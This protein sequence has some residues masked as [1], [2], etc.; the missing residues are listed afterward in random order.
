MNI[1]GGDKRGAKLATCNSTAVRPTGQRTREALFNILQGGRFSVSVAGAVVIDLF[2]G[3]GAIGL[4]ALSRGADQALFVEQDRSALKT[5]Q[6]NIT[7]L[8]MQSRSVILAQD[9]LT[10]ARWPHPAADLI[11]A[12][13]P[14][15]SGLAGQA[16]DRLFDVGA[17]SQKTVI[18]VETR[19]TDPCL[20]SP[21]FDLIDSRSYGIAKLNF[22]ALASD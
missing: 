14:Y 4:E 21:H 2:A 11:F 12:D 8:G 3:T 6:A 20:L 5:L 7:K 9:A 16:L 17:I 15:D 19:K 10:I 22:F 13:P 1:I 18:V